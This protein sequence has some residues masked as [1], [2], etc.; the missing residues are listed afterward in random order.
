MSRYGPPF[1]PSRG[2]ARNGESWRLV[3]LSMLLLGVSCVGC[4]DAESRQV[5]TVFAAASLSDVF[6]EV[7]RSIEADHP[8]VDVRLSFAGSSALREKILDGAPADVFASAN[9]LVMAD[10]V[11]SGDATEP[12]GFATNRLVIARS[13][14][15]D[16]TV[17]GLVDFARDAP[18]LGACIPEVPC[19]STAQAV[20]DVA[21]VEPNLDTEEPDVRR[22]LAKIVDG[23]L[24]AGLVYATD[25]RAG[26]DRVTVIEL[27]PGSVATAATT[28]Y[29]VALLDRASSSEAAQVVVDF[30]VSSEGR[31]LLE[32]HGFET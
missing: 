1:A 14:D 13:V 11:E 6:V 22:L 20:F 7:E 16:D 26:G 29:S 12:V 28:R 17:S 31:A 18:L 4:G 19:G 9:E 2:G 21:G 24:D 3:A 23:E 25:A 15:G 5:V 8:S 32:S 10:V 30:I 27:P